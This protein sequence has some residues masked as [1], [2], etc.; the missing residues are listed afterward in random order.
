FKEGGA[1]SSSGIY[2]KSFDC[3]GNKTRFAINDQ[4]HCELKRYNCI[5]YVGVI[6]P[7]FA[8]RAYL[9]KIIPYS[10]VE[11]WTVGL[12]REDGSPSRN[13]PIRKTLEL[14]GDPL[15]DIEGSR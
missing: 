3:Q 13:F 4:K 15:F 9:T 5:G 6:C 14:Y 2:V 8:R 11:T 1:S 7:P 12:L 10:A